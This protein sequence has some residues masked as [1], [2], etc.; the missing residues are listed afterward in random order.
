MNMSGSVIFLEPLYVE[1]I[2]FIIMELAYKMYKTCDFYGVVIPRIY[3]SLPKTLLSVQS[4][5]FLISSTSRISFS[6][7]FAICWFGSSFSL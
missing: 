5:S 1:T 6:S 4:A 3:K 2:I 7:V